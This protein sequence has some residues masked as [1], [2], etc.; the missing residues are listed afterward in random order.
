L[1]KRLLGCVLS[2]SLCSLLGSDLLFEPSSPFVCLV[3]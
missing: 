3:Q 2:A 1:L